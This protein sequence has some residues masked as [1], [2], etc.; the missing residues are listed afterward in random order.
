MEDTK[1]LTKRFVINTFVSLFPEIDRVTLD[2]F[3]DAATKSNDPKENIEMSAELLKELLADYI[4]ERRKQLIKAVE[5]G[6]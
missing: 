1:E 6:K 2:I 5:K 3:I 4:D